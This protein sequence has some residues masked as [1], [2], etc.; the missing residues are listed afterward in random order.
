MAAAVRAQAESGV[1][2]RDRPGRGAVSWSDAIIDPTD[3]RRLVG[4][5]FDVLA[6]KR[7]RL[8]KRRHDNTPL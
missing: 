3:T 4:A 1:L 5:C 2:D 8:P 7:E 6:A